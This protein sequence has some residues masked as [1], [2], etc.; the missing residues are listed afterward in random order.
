ME[1]RDLKP[2]PP[3]SQRDGPRPGELP[4]EYITR[5]MAELRPLVTATTLPP[6]DGATSLPDRLRKD[7]EVLEKATGLDPKS[8]A[9]ATP[10]ERV[11][12]L[13]DAERALA[14]AQGREAG[15]VYLWNLQH[16]PHAK[17]ESVLG[18][19]QS[20]SE[21]DSHS[22]LLAPGNVIRID[23]NL[24]RDRPGAPASFNDAIR[25]FAE[26]SRYLYQTSVMQRPDRHPEVDDQTRFMWYRAA[27]NYPALDSSVAEYLGNALKSDAK[28]YATVICAALDGQRF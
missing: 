20:V 10:H 27:E 6:G 23:V 26:G 4:S 21:R 13:R 3:L 12:I 18:V 25:T 24:P 15:R 1:P 8:W 16:T 28:R 14:A 7:I 9:T 11:T 17:G 2:A 22:T 19:A 5:T